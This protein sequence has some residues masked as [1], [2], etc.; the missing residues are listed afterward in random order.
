MSTFKAKDA[1]ALEKDFKSYGSGTTSNPYIPYHLIDGY[2]NVTGSVTANLGSPNVYATGT[3][4]I[5]NTP[6]PVTD[7]GGSLTVDGTVSVGNTITVSDDG[8]FNVNVQGTASVQT[9]G[10]NTVS[11][12]DN[13]GSLTVDGYVTSTGTVSVEGIVSV[14]DGGGSLTIDAASLPLPSGAATAANQ[15]PDGHNVTIDNASGASAVNIQDGG[16]SITV[17]GTVNLGATDNAVLDQI[18]L[19][20]SYGDNTGGGTE[21]G[22]LRVTLANDSTGLISVDDNAGSLTVDNTN[23]DALQF[24]VQGES[25]SLA[26]VHATGTTVSVVIETDNAGIGGGVQYTEDDPSAGGETGTFI[27][28]VRNDAGTTPVSTDGDYHGI[29]FDNSGRLR[30]VTQGGAGGTSSVDEATF[31]LASDSGTPAMGYVGQDSLATGTVGV[32]GMTADRQ[33][34]V[35]IDADNAGIGG[36]TEYTEDDPAAGGESGKFILG[37]RNDA[38]TS[39]VSADGDYHGIQFDNSGRL[40]VV[41]QGGAGGT[42]SVDEATFTLGSDSGTPAMGYVGEDSLATGTVGVLGMTADRQLRVVI[43]QDNAGIGGGT[44]YTEDDAAPANPVGNALMGRRTDVRSDEVSADGDWVAINANKY[45]ELLIFEHNNIDTNNSTTA[46]LGISGVFTGTATDVSDFASVTITLDSDVDSATDGMVFEFSTDATNWDDSYPFTYT[47]AD[48]AR[49]FQFP[50]TA[51]YFRIFYTNGAVGQSHFRVQT[52]LHTKSV[53][54][55]IHRMQDNVSQDRSATVVKAAIVAQINGTGDFTPVQSDSQG[56]LKF[57]LE[58]VGGTAVD[59]N[60]GNA[61]N[62]TQRVVLASDQ[63][64]VSID[65]NGASLTVDGSVTLGANDGVDVGDVT[66]NN[67]AGASAVN[68]QDGGNSITVDDGGT[69]LSV[70]GTVT[71]NAG[72][73]SFNNDSVGAE[74]GAVTNGVLIQG[75]DG[76]DRKNVNVD[77]TTGDVQVDVTNTVTVSDNGSFTLAA[78][79]GVDIGDV[80]LNNATG[81]GTEASALRVT[82]ANDSTGVLSVDDNGTT[83]S[84]DDGAGS[85]TVDGGV[86]VEGSVAH[87]AADADNPVKVGH[88]AIAHGTNPT[89]VAANDVSDWYTNRHGI[90][91][92]I[93]GH[94]NIVTT[95][96]NYTA[97]QTDTAI[98]TVGA[99]TK[100]VVTRVSVTSDNATSVDV[101]A[102]IG[103]GATT[104]PTTTGVVLSHPGIAAGSGVVEGTGAGMLGVGADGE[105]LRITSEVPTSGSIDVVVSYYTIES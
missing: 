97:A 95:R 57:D 61:G 48:G 98:V 70:D 82:V 39:P 38:G 80:T 49:R 100:I 40:R 25:N 52:I 53:G 30:V 24:G 83:L 6:I 32:L 71:A 81:G 75:D 23:I 94:P 68:I 5:G 28:G 15:L 77:P 67:A 20:T 96:A 102:R 10:G 36:G 1:N 7:N 86:T 37:V 87:D 42:S 27:L 22:S 59:T 33:L 51:Q 13:G 64:V 84:V 104:T 74:T 55:S 2:V 73:G 60:T 14:D 103:F 78:N 88:K 101:Q 93:G 90:P 85:L 79:D 21:A 54:N 66:I 105:D 69:T 9:T 43:D 8:A 92:V 29:Q 41:T 12:D 26:V 72:T 16:N 44:Q 35:V 46:T 89:A 62:G 31:T 65:D 63:P 47:A 19:N 4:N 76:T 58:D 34:R 50:V 91:W 99:G 17:D 3:V 45:G 11:V 18:E 56:N